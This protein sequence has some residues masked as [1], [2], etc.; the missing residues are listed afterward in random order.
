MPPAFASL[1]PREL[2]DGAP[3]YIK[4]CGHLVTAGGRGGKEVRGELLV[5][6]QNNPET[7][8]LY[9]GALASTS[10]G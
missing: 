4:P 7:L 10:P 9:G 8:A 5:S 3:I 6:S 2:N 1:S